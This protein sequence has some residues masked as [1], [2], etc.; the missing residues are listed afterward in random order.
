MSEPDDIDKL[1]REIDAMNKGGGPA[2][3]VPA[4]TQGKHVEQPAT[5]KTGGGR[6]VAWAG[7]SAVGGLVV[8]GFT[9]TVLAVLPYVGPVTTGLGAA[10]GAAAAGFV[11]RPPAWFQRR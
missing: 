8:G 5:D 10:L 7:T 1:L 2:Q 6:R 11:S 9:G 4:T 3:P